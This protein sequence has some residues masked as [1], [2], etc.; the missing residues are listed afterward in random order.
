MFQGPCSVVQHN[1]QQE[2]IYLLSSF[3]LLFFFVKPACNC[4]LSSFLTAVM[5]HRT[6]KIDTFLNLS[7]FF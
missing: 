3:P 2:P 7:F 1:S 5:E 4:I 6:W